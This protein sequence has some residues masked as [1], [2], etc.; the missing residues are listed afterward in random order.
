MKITLKTTLPTH[1]TT[2]ISQLLWLDL[3]QTLKVGS[4]EHLEHIEPNIAPNIVCWGAEDVKRLVHNMPFA[5]LR[6]NP[7]W[8]EIK[9]FENMLVL[10]FLPSSASTSTPTLAEVSLILEFIFPPT[11]QISS[12]ISQISS[13]TS[14][15]ISSG[16]SQI[17]S[18]TS[19]PPTPN[20]KSILT[21]FRLNLNCI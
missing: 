16:T 14:N 6:P 9:I 20:R 17:S 12:G 7:N 10:N 3:D 11:H 15:Q 8:T 4:W 1:P 13:G 21:P 5:K 2:Q 19:N 18:G